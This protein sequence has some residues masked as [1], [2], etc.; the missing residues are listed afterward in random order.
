VR[1]ERVVIR[2]GGVSGMV[3]AYV[4]LVWAV[5]PLVVFIVGS[6]RDELKGKKTE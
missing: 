5:V 2:F 6:I 1:F 3:E 4:M